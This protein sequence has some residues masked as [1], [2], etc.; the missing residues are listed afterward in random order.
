MAIHFCTSSAGHWNIS[1]ANI[2]PSRSLLLRT[3]SPMTF[4]FFTRFRHRSS[5]T[6]ETAAFAVAFSAIRRAV[7]STS[8]AACLATEALRSASPSSSNK[9]IAATPAAASRMASFDTLRST[10]FTRKPMPGADVMPNRRP[11]AHNTAPCRSSRA[12]STSLH[13]NLLTRSFVMGSGTS[14]RPRKF[15][16]ANPRQV[17]TRLETRSSRQL[18]AR[19]KY[20]STHLTISWPTSASSLLS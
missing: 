7:R 17:N 3:A 5:K 10:Y 1:T 6:S 14:A 16:G 18:A 15:I 19:T 13:I 4:D 2:L 20:A 11:I 8:L 12:P 9:P